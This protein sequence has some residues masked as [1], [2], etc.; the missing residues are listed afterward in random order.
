[1]WISNW[2]GAMTGGGGLSAGSPGSPATL[3][4]GT[5]ASGGGGSADAFDPLGS[6][7]GG[8]T[9]AGGPGGFVASGIG[10]LMGLAGGA[11]PS[12]PPS[13]GWGGG[14]LP[15]PSIQSIAT[16]GP[17]GGPLPGPAPDP[18][19][20]PGH[21]PG[22]GGWQ[23]QGGGFSGLAAI[24]MA[25]AAAGSMFPGGAAAA[26]VA[27]KL[28][29]RAIGFAGQAASIGIQGLFQTFLPSGSDFADPSKSWPGRILGGF[30]GAR[31][32][33][34]GSA[35]KTTEVAPKPQYDVDPNGTQHGQG[36]GQPPGPLI[37]N[38]NY[39][40]PQADGQA[41]ARDISRQTNAYGA[42]QGH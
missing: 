6:F 42:G 13:G 24:D 35:G 38:L 12:A 28:A 10:N 16:G 31:P 37:G 7:L 40:G 34:S 26:Q 14:A 20:A 32:A 11:S 15:A 23:P 2:D 4:G 33:D 22:A 5:G 29:N 41:V 18:H 30:A 8:M 21:T 9:S 19:T 1:V 39:T 27:T 36:H 3:T 25:G 17:G